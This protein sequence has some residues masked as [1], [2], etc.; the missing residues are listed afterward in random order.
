MSGSSGPTADAPNQ[1]PKRT[2]A[3]RGRATGIRVAARRSVLLQIRR[4]GSMAM[5]DCEQKLI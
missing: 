4:S 3:A 1:V 2:V 5:F